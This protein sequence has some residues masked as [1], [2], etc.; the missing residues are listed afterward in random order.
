M[1]IRC[2]VQDCPSVS[3]SEYQPEPGWRALKVSEINN[4][5]ILISVGQGSMC[6]TCLEAG[7][8][9]PLR[10]AADQVVAPPKPEPKPE[11]PAAEELE[12]VEAEEVEAEDITPA[13]EQL[14]GSPP[15]AQE[16]GEELG[17]GGLAGSDDLGVD[18]LPEAAFSVSGHGPVE[19]PIAEGAA[20][21]PQG[22]PP[23]APAPTAPEP[24]RPHRR[25]SK[26]S[27]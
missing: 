23:P 5:G 1:P 14:G 9:P 11:K 6:V 12:E 16:Q 22:S 17:I 4:G 7:R 3:E 8:L 18:P 27:T 2:I 25:R 24:G 21:G 10:S 13:P 15:P 20:P 19:A 26:R